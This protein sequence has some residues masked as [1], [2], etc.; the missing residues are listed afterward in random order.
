MKTLYCAL[1]VL[2]GCLF[3]PAVRAD[4]VL[5]RGE[6]A[7]HTND[8]NKDH[9]T[10]VYVTVAT[11]DGSSQLAHISNGDCGG[12][13]STEYNNGSD[14][15]IGMQIDASGASKDA[16]KGFTV[17]LWQKTHGGAGHDTWKFDARVVLYFSDELN[18]VAHTEGVVLKSN[19]TSDAPSVSFANK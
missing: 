14:H 1:A 6:L 19:S 15:S 10:C 9:D 3:A 17:L 18:L 4:A 11:A 16:C 7:T 8:D 12:D 13:D 2:L 5:I